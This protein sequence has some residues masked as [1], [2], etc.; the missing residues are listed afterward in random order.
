MNK[1]NSTLN[2]CCH[3]LVL[4]ILKFSFEERL[5]LAQLIFVLRCQNDF[6]R[7]FWIYDNLVIL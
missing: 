3:R 1:L 4:K 2:T 5:I 7:S 6:N